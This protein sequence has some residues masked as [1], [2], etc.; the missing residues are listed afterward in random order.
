MKKQQGFT[1]T[2]IA[3][4]I[5][6]IGLLL[7]SILKGQQIIT[8]AKIKNIEGSFNN[9]SKAIYTYR[10]RYGKL[11]GDDN[12]VERFPIITSNSEHGGNGN[13]L[14]DSSVPSP[15]INYKMQAQKLE[16]GKV[17]LHL[18]VA[19]LVKGS[20]DPTKTE[21]SLSSP[22]RG[23]TNAFGGKTG[24]GSGLPC[25]AT[26]STPIQGEFIGFTHIPSNIAAIIDQNNDDNTPY[27]GRI[28]AEDK[29]DKPLKGTCIETEKYNDPQQQLTSLL[30]FL[31]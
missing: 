25:A 12:E 15:F 7:G 31:N 28:R 18:R 24:I 8:T 14:I 4:V 16:Y 3:I 11:P 29:P 30:F 2:E 22:Y 1:L 10:E 27:T 19:D 6:I 23:P 9:L 26:I 17:W 5:V 13:G 21:S 20:T